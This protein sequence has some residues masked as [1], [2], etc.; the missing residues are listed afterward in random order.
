MWWAVVHPREQAR[1]RRRSRTRLGSR[2]WV[3]GGE[4]RRNSQRGIRFPFLPRLQVLHFLSRFGL[5]GH[6]FQST[7]LFDRIRFG[8]RR[9]RGGDTV[10]RFVWPLH[11]GARA[12]GHRRT[13]TCASCAMVSHRLAM[14]K[15]GRTTAHRL[16]MLRCVETRA[17]RRH[18]GSSTADGLTA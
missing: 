2:A 8:S 17:N 6:V 4:E 13:R 14:R 3:G 11:G 5:I 10:L 1:V 15:L 12:L 7:F 18:E 16:S 9:G